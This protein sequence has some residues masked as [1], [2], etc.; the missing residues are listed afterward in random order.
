[1]S[2]GPESCHCWASDDFDLPI[3]PTCLI[4]LPSLKRG[5]D[6]GPRWEPAKRHRSSA[7]SPQ[8]DGLAA[9]LP[10]RHPRSSRT[11]RR[12]GSPLGQ[13]MAEDFRNPRA[14]EQC[15]CPAAGGWQQLSISPRGHEIVQTP[16]RA[17]RQ[18][19]GMA[20]SKSGCRISSRCRCGRW[21]A[22]VRIRA[23]TISVGSGDNAGIEG[24]Y[25]DRRRYRP[26]CW[27]GGR[28]QARGLQY[29]GKVLARMRIRTPTGRAGVGTTSGTCA[30]G[31]ARLTKV[32]C[33]CAPETEG[34][35]KCNHGRYCGT[36]L[37]DGKDVGSILIS[38]NLAVPFVCGKTSCP[39]TPRPWCKG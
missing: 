6:D 9:N 32:A 13:T 36:L 3:F 22:S 23:R 31:T 28:D 39:P 5:G 38:K 8:L 26:R 10:D 4:T 19:V 33:A 34:T 25:G 18:T 20:S 15:D 37:V 14:T 7:A 2:L 24:F 35:K 1:M 30:H 12:T 17:S 29:A 11:I 21:T 16:F 27:G